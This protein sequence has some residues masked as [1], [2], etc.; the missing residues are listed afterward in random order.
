MSFYFMLLTEGE[1]KESIFKGN[2][3]SFAFGKT[4]VPPHFVEGGTYALW[5]PY[6]I[7]LYEVPIF[8]VLVWDLKGTT[9]SLCY[10]SSLVNKACDLWSS[11]F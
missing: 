1:K 11:S 4:T 2:S 5:I 8:T 10:F 6:Y 7:N 9:S 3:S